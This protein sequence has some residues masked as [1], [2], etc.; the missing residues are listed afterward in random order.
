M[1][2]V[3]DSIDISH[4]I[5]IWL[6]LFDQN[7][8]QFVSLFLSPYSFFDKWSEWRRFIN[9]KSDTGHFFSHLKSANF[10]PAHVDDVDG[11]I[12]ILQEL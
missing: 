5:F 8:I 4:I 9:Q 6:L 2:N 3:A 12:F 10:L 7:P 1:E 11:E